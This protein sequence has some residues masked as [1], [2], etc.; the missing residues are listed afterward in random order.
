MHLDIIYPLYIYSKLLPINS[1]NKLVW[2]CHNSET[3]HSIYVIEIMYNYYLHRDPILL[4]AH[5]LSQNVRSK[6]SPVRT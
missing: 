4:Y 6:T 1:G 3:T 5:N 2:V